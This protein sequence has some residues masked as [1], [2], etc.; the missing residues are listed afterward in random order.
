MQDVFGEIDYNSL[1]PEQIRMALNVLMFMTQ[2]RD[3]SIKSRGYI[4]GRPQ[5]LWTNKHETA[6]LTPHTESVKYTCQVDAKEGRE[7]AIG[8]LK[9][10]FLQTESKKF[11]ILRIMGDLALALVAYDAKW[12]K[13]LR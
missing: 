5:Q 4:D 13:H 3:G 6:S 1:T 12:K 9:G 8:D 7:V 11:I 2:K 10:F